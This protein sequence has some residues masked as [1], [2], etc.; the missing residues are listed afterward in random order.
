MITQARLRDFQT[1]IER[2][3]IK[4]VQPECYELHP[5]LRQYAREKANNFDPIQ[6]RYLAFYQTKLTEFV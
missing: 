2:S 3:V 1:L 6:K 5:L 4:R